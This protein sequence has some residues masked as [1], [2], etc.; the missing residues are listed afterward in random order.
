M[1]H[2]TDSDGDGIPDAWMLYYFGHVTGPGRRSSSRASKD[3]A[4]GDGM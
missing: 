3:D 4:D 1:G 2:G